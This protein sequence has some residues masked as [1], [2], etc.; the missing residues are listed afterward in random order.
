MGTSNVYRVQAVVDR[1]RNDKELLSFG[2]TVATKTTG[3]ANFTPPPPALAD[4]I[5]ALPIFAAAIATAATEKGTAS[6]L[7]SARQGVVDA[8]DHLRDQGQGVAQK[9]APD[10]GKATIESMGFRTKTVTLPTKP[11]FA[12]KYGSLSGSVLLAVIA[13]ARDATYFWEYSTDQK[14]W[15]DCPSTMKAMTTVSGLTV[16]TVYYFRF[17]AQTRKGMRDWSQPVSLLVR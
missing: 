8:L 17:R 5:A 6:S 10:T 12:A 1:P 14:T 4:L 13:V 9:Q 3:N 2:Q 16:A 15:T 7:A 11:A